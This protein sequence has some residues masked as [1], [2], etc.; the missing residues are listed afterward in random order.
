MNQRTASVP[1][2]LPGATDSCK[3]LDRQRYLGNSA[4]MRAVS[5]TL[6]RVSSTD[7]TVLVWGES[8]VGKEMIAKLLHEKSARR[9]GPLIKVNC[10]ALPLELLES[11]LFGYERGAFTGAHRQKP[12]KFELANKGT[13]FLDEIGEL[14][15]PLQAKLL[16]ILQDREYARLGG[17][18]TVRV[19]ARVVVATNK[20]L[21][22]LVHQRLFREDLYYRLNVVNIRVPALRQRREELPYLIDHFLSKFNQEYGRTHP[23]VRPDTLRHFLQYPWPGNIRELENIMKRIVVLGTE[24]WVPDELPLALAAT[25]PADTAHNGATGEHAWSLTAIGRRAAAEA[26]RI[27]LT[28]VLEEVRWNRMEAAR[29]LKVNYKTILAKIDEYKIGDRQGTRGAE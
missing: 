11:E 27:A 21:A 10:A 9:D 26:E 28:R 24:A 22:D 16:H 18:Q 14:P 19:D 2:G 25:T 12:G 20:D 7:V 1:R 23:S 17:A 29:R 13:I 6:D 5:A 15:W 3:E 4:A 8:G